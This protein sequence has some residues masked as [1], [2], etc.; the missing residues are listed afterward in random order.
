MVSWKENVE[1]IRTYFRT[2]VAIFELASD[3]GLL[4][5]LDE[6]DDCVSRATLSF[7]LERPGLGGGPGRLSRI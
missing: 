7:D 5:T 2:L 4:S 6:G 1:K 3:R